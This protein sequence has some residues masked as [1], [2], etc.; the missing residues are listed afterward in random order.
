MSKVSKSP[1]R[2]T[3]QKEGY[4][5]RTKETG[6]EP[7]QSYLNW[8]D[9]IRMNEDKK[10]Q[11]LEWQKNNLEYDLRSTDWI[12]EKVR[13]SDNYAQNIYAALCNNDFMK[14]AVVPILKEETWSCSW[15]HAGGIVANMQEKGDYIDWYCS[16]IGNSED[17]YGLAGNNPEQGAYVQES[18]VTIEVREDLKKLGWIVMESEKD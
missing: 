14:L 16:G 6:K 4:I 2:N 1:E 11:D 9:E 12:L 13:A 7:D 18:V 15:R 3:F 5:E 17:G 8:F 10:V